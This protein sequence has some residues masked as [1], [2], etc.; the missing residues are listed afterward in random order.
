MQ[1]VDFG[2]EC[3]RAINKETKQIMRVYVNMI[4]AKK[5]DCFDSTV[6]NHISGSWY[7]N[8]SN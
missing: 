2:I 7:S 6:K 1:L 4:Y 8:T 3:L 5:I